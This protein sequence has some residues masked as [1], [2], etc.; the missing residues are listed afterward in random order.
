MII[1][2]YSVFRAM[3]NPGGSLTQDG[4]TEFDPTLMR[5]GGFNGGFT[6]SSTS[7]FPIVV[8]CNVGFPDSVAGIDEYDWYVS[9]QTST[10]ANKPL[11]VSR[12]DTA[13][14]THSGKIE[15][16]LA[17]WAVSEYA[18]PFDLSTIRVLFF[19]ID[20]YAIERLGGGIQRLNLAS[21]LSSVL[22][23]KTDLE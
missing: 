13:P 11:T 23:P 6:L 4:L 8:S 22:S 10:A 21:Y 12:K 9:Q 5:T 20:I 18:D 14:N 16:D 1:D 7:A 3:A 2:N 19:G 17:A 15:I